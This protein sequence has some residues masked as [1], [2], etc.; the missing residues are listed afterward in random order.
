M[1]PLPW[2]AE[3]LRFTCQPECGK[4][5]TR[6][7]AY[8]YVYLEDGDDE[9]LAEHLGLDLATFRRT[10][11]ARDDGHLILKMEEPACPFLD[12]ARCRVYEARP[13]QCR[14]FPFWPENLRSR[15][16]WERLRSFC[17]GIGEGKLLSLPEI[18]SWMANE[19]A[20]DGESGA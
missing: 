12:G 19:P 6:H 9:R 3:G 4:C 10:H 8:G 11:T 14:T 2:Y 13:T 15:A 1:S 7:G 20:R 17:P 16:R 5:C 18:R